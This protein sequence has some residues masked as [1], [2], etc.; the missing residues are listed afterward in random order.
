VSAFIQSQIK[1]V[2]PTNIFI[3]CNYSA[4]NNGKLDRHYTFRF[5]PKYISIKNNG[6]E[7]Y[8]MT[9]PLGCEFIVGQQPLS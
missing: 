9:E 3:E 5:V 7:S 4:G 6:I 1:E 8:I 2:V